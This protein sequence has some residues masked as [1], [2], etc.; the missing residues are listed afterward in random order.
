MQRPIA[1][2]FHR[3]GPYHCARLRAVATCEP[4]IGI[5]IVQKDAT[6]PWDLIVGNQGFR[7][8]TLFSGPT[9]DIPPI[10]ELGLR[11][12]ECLD[13]YRPRAVAIPGWS[14]PYAL[15]AL[16]WCLKTS[17]PA[18]LLTDS[19]ALDKRH[20]FVENIKRRLLSLYSAALAAG[21]RQIEYLRHLGFPEGAAFPGCDVVDNV[22]FTLSQ[23]RDTMTG[24]VRPY[25]LACCRFI[26]V[27][28]LPR[29]LHAY[30][31]Y[32]RR[33]EH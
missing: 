28:N 11:L 1:I 8:V 21:R 24:R 31:R 2:I 30:A 4:V 19:T 22:H 12:N 5:E 14:L 25:F 9:G 26:A 13:E 29:L 16:S 32:R 23:P 6:Y 20:R 33:R 15:L 10:R 17:T 18:V 7:R 3:F 27:K